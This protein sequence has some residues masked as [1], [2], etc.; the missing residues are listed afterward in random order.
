MSENTQ[1]LDA[2]KTILD[3]AV[4]LQ[5]QI[6]AVVAT[7][8]KYRE[9]INSLVRETKQKEI[10]LEAREK[11]IRQHEHRLMSAEEMDKRQ[12]QLEGFAADI[13]NKLK[14]CDRECAEKVAVASE[15]IA[16]IESLRKDLETREKALEEEKRTYKDKV[17]RMM[18]KDPKCN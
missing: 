16:L 18:G 5:T 15:E 14:A 7:A 9:E 6:Q 10:D 1:V 4:A 17:L 12:N 2:I 11:A 13:E 8:D 3:K